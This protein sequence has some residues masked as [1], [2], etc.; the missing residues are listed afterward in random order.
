MQIY[1]TKERKTL[2]NEKRASLAKEIKD[3]ENSI[4]FIKKE[5]YLGKSVLNSNIILKDSIKNLFALIPDSIHLT[6][7]KIGKKS[8]KLYG[9]TPSKEVYN[10]LLLPPLKSIFINSTVSFYPI[11]NGW[12]RFVSINSSDEEFVYET[13]K[14]ISRRRDRCC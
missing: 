6:Q 5:I 2:F 1:S 4:T 9:Y 8:L 11:G 13:Q 7:A 10:N 14:W 3:I 12:F